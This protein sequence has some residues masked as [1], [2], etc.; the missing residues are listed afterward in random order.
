MSGL[1]LPLRPMAMVT[2]P[3]KL[4]TG[5]SSA[6]SAVTGPRLNGHR[7]SVYSAGR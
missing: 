2:G 1:M 6:F 4:V 3:L 7:G 5:L